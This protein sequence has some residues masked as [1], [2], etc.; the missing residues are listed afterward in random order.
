MAGGTN[1]GYDEPVQGLPIIVLWLLA[2]IHEYIS[3]IRTFGNLAGDYTVG[4]ESLPSSELS[5]LKFICIG[6]LR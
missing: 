5:Q 4:S 2:S 3:W 1:P 6:R